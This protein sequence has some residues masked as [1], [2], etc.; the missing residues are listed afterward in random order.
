MGGDE[1]WVAFIPDTLKNIDPAWMW[2][3]TAF[4]CCTVIEEKV[5]GGIVKIGAHS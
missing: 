5:L 4:G 1:D 2:E 3:G